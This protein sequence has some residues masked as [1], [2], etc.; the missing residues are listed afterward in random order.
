MLTEE[1]KA[2]IEA[3]TTAAGE[4]AKENAKWSTPP[5]SGDTLIGAGAGETKKDE[6]NGNGAGDVKKDSGPDPD[7]GK[8]GAPDP[9]SKGGSEKTG[10]SGDGN[11]PASGGGH[12][13]VSPATIMRAITA[14]ISAADAFALGDDALVDNLIADKQSKERAKEEEAELAAVRAEETKAIEQKQKALLDKLP[15]LD[16]DET[17]PAILAS[18]EAMKSIIME[19]QNQLEALRASHESQLSAADVAREK[20][21]TT[22]FEGRVTKLTEEFGKV[23]S[24]DGINPVKITTERGDAIAS[25]VA[26]M[27]EGYRASG[28]KMPSLDSMFDEAARIVLKDEYAR[29]DEVQL[30]ERM[31]KR[32]NQEISRPGG[33]KGK[34][35]KS[36]VDEVADMLNKRYFSDR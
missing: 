32:S 34:T 35:E 33:S 22:W 1:F 6:G 2:E 3:A 18:Y 11:V 31:E 21:L 28:I 17:D 36:P 7:S 4:T 19:Q 16:P 29:M 9:E 5:A 23:L 12:K 20:E 27:V 8:G 10:G 26:I 30:T 14:G 15:T 24:K 25:K 13:G